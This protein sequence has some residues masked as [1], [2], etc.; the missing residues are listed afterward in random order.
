MEAAEA[1]RAGC[2]GSRRGSGRDHNDEPQH[3]LG[4]LRPGSTRGRA[5]PG[6]RVLVMVFLP[7]MTRLSFGGS[8]PGGAGALLK[9][10]ID[11]PDQ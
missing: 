6:A 7:A 3:D 11:G 8:A 2:R 1:G 4:L 9:G 10:L 5:G